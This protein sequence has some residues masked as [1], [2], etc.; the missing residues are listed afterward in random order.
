MYVVRE[1][2]AHK[3]DFK[4][5]GRKKILVIGDSFAEDFMNM[6]S[7]NHLLE[8]DQVRTFGITAKCQIIIPEPNPRL[9]REHSLLGAAIQARIKQADIIILASSWLPE[10]AARLDATLGAA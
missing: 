3:G 9:C 8:S 10:T 5:N 7:E 2:S 1:F 6:L 4:D